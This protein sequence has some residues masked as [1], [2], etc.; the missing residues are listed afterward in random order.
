MVDWK[1]NNFD[2]IRLLAAFQVALKHAL[3]HL[4]FFP[5]YLEN[6]IDIFPGVP[7]FFF[8]SG[9]LIYRAFEKNCEK[10]FHLYNFFLNRCLRLYPSL[11]CCFIFSCVILI[12]TGYLATAGP[13]FQD[14]LAWSFT[15]L[16]MFQFYNPEFLREFGVGAINGSLWSISVEIQFTCHTNIFLILSYRF[17]LPLLVLDFFYCTKRLLF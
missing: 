3:Y 12:S 8:I 16:T 15:S 7:I 10:D 4:D 9:F 14:L 1:L 11:F 13:K 17:A 5:D 2:L 6:I